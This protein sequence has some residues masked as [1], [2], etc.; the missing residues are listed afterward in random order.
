MAAKKK[1]AGRARSAAR[2]R[3]VIAKRRFWLMYPPRMI[4]TPVI[5]ELGQKFSV[6]TNVRQ[7][8]VT[9]EIGIVC[10]ELD[11]KPAEVDA[12]VTWLEKSGINV[13][14]VEITVLES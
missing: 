8:S 13:E 1:K 9:D 5:W 11:G 7:A 6:V 4:K 14:P 3:D 2:G 12:A 10:L